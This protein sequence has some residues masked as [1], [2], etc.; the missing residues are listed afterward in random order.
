MSKE[1]RK[2]KNTTKT[3]EYSSIETKI[4]CGMKK[5]LKISAHHTKGGQIDL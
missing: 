2:N 1:I 5:F 4:H 3:F